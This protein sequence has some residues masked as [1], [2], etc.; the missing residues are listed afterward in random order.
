MGRSVIRARNVDER[1]LEKMFGTGLQLTEP[2]ETP[3]GPYCGY[4]ANGECAGVNDLDY[5]RCSI[6]N[7]DNCLVYQIKEQERDE[8]SDDVRALSDPLEDTVI[9]HC[10]EIVSSSS[11]D[12][13]IHDQMAEGADV[14]KFFGIRNTLRTPSVDYR[15]D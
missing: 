6:L 12:E 7:C 14:R 15:A 10:D 4:G 5:V 2:K 9:M 1:R 3:R 13:S 8:A 11:Y